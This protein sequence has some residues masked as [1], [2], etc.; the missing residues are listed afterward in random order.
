VARAAIK[1]HD[2]RTA[3]RPAEQVLR[4]PGR[5]CST[6]RA[7]LCSAASWAPSRSSKDVELA[8]SIAW[9]IDS[10]TDQAVALAALASVLVLDGETDRAD[11]ILSPSTGPNVSGWGPVALIEARA[12]LAGALTG[13]P[14]CWSRG[15]RTR[16]T[17]SQ[18][19]TT[20]RG[21]WSRWP[22]PR[23]TGHVACCCGIPVRQGLG[24]S[25]GH[26]V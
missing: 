23:R 2:T 24:N 11:M 4:P 8:E 13:G 19:Q 12:I 1:A 15:S 9:S 7:N 26:I 22:G 20:E 5:G 17:R 16:P 18:D 3:A 21:H 6:G 14:P 10:W 25:D